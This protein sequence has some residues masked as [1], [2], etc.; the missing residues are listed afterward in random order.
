MAHNQL[1]GY[2]L[3]P[4]EHAPL[5]GLRGPCLWQSVPGGGRLA[6]FVTPNTSLL[7]AR[8]PD[9]QRILYLW[10]RPV[11]PDRTV[12]DL[13]A[14]CLD[15]F[16]REDYAPLKDLL[17]SFVIVV[18][19]PMHERVLIA[20]DILGV[21]HFFVGHHEGRLIFGSE[22]WPLYQ[23]GLVAGRVDYDAVAA[24]LMYRYNCT[25]GSLFQDLSRVPPGAVT[26]VEQGTTR[27]IPYVT[28]E[29]R[30]EQA[31]PEGQ[32]AE[33]LHAI[34]LETMKALS[35]QR[36]HFNLA[37]SGGYDSRYL[38]GLLRTLGAQPQT[39]LTVAGHQQALTAR[40][41]AAACGVPYHELSMPGSEW[42]L[43]R[44][45][46]V[47]HDAPDG[48]PITK[49]LTHCVAQACT[50]LPL[51][52]GFLGDPLMRGSKDTYQGHYDTTWT[53]NLAHALQ[54]KHGMAVTHYRSRVARRLIERSLAPMEE[55]VWQG[56]KIGKVFGWTDVFYRQR[57]YIANNFLQHLGLSEAL[58]P[59]YHWALVD[60]KFS[61]PYGTCTRATYMRMMQQTSPQLAEISRADEV[62]TASH[63]RPALAQCARLW[64]GHLLKQ[65]RTSHHLALLSR[66]HCIPRLMAGLAGLHRAEPIIVETQRLHLFETHM[67]RAGVDFT[68]DRL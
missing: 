2:Q 46:E 53:G 68:W 13:S 37:L 44:P 10:G 58:L 18:D 55:A 42:D 23:A 32:T 9:T 35:A 11:H 36:P 16:L 67:A 63:E 59:F 45:E 57:L 41:V 12:T 1:Y 48:F 51:M 27:V 6:V 64:A 65:L 34:M 52:T 60:Y 7:T 31:A 20:S 26:I 17:G 19:D 8:D 21:R 3:L 66:T 43:Y 28:W 15:L 33:S 29:F 50:P 4:G 49:N 39:C 14:W 62:R 5:G 30:H 38:L 22:V 47:Y 25:N 24:W 54:R 40:Q 61:H 56:A